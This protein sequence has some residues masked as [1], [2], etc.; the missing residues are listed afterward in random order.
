MTGAAPTDGLPVLAF[1]D[2]KAWEAW[3]LAHAD[4]TGVW[5]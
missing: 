1:A 4:G 2:P 3:R 5:V